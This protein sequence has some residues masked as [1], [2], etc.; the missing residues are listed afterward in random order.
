MFLNKIA[1]KNMKEKF[2]SYDDATEAF[3]PEQFAGR[4]DLTD[5]FL[6]IYNRPTRKRVLFTAPDTELPE[7][8]VMR[9]PMTGEVYIVGSPRQDA[10]WDVEGGSP[11]VK[12][13][14]LHLVTPT[15]T[16]A[17]IA[18]HKRRVMGSTQDWLTTTVLGNEYMDVEFRTS[19]SEK[20]VELGQIENYFAWLPPKTV[21]DTHD[22]LTLNDVDYLV[23]DVYE[24]MGMCALRVAKR[25]D[26]RMDLLIHR[27]T[28]I[29]NNDTFEYEITTVAEKVTGLIPKHT[30]GSAW[31][32]GTSAVINIEAEHILFKPEVDMEVT[33]GGRKLTIQSV[34]L[35]AGET[36]WRLEVG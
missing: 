32:S 30:E 9:H 14:M 11:Y 19:S 16:T 7:S 2:D 28:K 34:F 27:T 6:S 5:R 13:S 3:L 26:P 20:D 10:R 22:T 35:Q 15:G 25:P 29:F 33:V 23:I 21:V 8:G 18:S 1:Q 17:G 24:E 4:I 36:Q 31:G 12:L